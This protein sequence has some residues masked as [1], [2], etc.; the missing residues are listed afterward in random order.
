MAQKQNALLQ[1]IAEQIKEKS[2][3]IDLQANNRAP[4]KIQEEEMKDDFADFS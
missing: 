4:Q 1:N 3:Q 2:D